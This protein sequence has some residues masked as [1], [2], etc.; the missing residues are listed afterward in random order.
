MKAATYP[1]ALSSLLFWQFW[2]AF[3]CWAHCHTFGF[4]PGIVSAQWHELL[5]FHFA[6]VSYDP[7]HLF[8]TCRFP[9]ILMSSLIIIFLNIVAW[10]CFIFCAS[11]NVLWSGPMALICVKP[12]VWMWVSFPFL[13]RPI[14]IYGI[15]W[16]EVSMSWS[17]WQIYLFI[18]MSHLLGKMSLYH[19]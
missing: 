19:M 1:R 2:H 15:S 17:N 11:S 18:T 6:W 4:C 5:G 3:C 9:F 10:T 14:L 13:A 8:A 12:G 7:K 16:V